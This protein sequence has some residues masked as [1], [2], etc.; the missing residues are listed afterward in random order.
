MPTSVPSRQRWPQDRLHGSS[1]EVTTRASQRACPFVMERGYDGVVGATRVNGSSAT[2]K[3]FVW[4]SC[5]SPIFLASCHASLELLGRP[6]NEWKSRRSALQQTIIK[7]YKGSQ[8]VA[9]A[10]YR[11]DAQRMAGQGYS[12]ISQVWT[13]GTWGCGSFILALLLCLILIGF[14]VF[15]YMLIVKPAGSLTVT[16]TLANQSGSEKVCP[17]CAEQVKAAAT[18][19]RFCGF[20]FDPEEICSAVVPTHKPVSRAEAFG[21]KLGKLFSDRRGM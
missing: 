8:A 16:Y 11:Q 7:T 12:P 17:K 5:T 20:E 13:A 4:A 3:M 10:E 9:T 1:T 19:C 6:I 2:T 14:L 21:H 18:V 15:I